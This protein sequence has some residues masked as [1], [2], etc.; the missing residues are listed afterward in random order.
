MRSD[1]VYG[2]RFLIA[3]MR[4]LHCQSQFRG[5]TL[6][7]KVASQS[8]VVQSERVSSRTSR[9]CRTASAVRKGG[10][11]QGFVAGLAGCRGGAALLR[12]HSQVLWRRQ[13]VLCVCLTICFC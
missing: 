10:S 2:P 5:H 9:A 7:V 6:T 3:A 8:R 12:R 1:I 11:H 4:A 13:L